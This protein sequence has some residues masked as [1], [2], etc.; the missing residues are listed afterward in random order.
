MKKIISIILT[1]VMLSAVVM[2]IP[3]GA[4]AE[5]ATGPV[6]RIG[7]T[8]YDT[9]DDAIDHAQV[10]DVIVLL[11]D[12]T[13]TSKTIDGK[14][15]TIKGEGTTK[16]IITASTTAK[17]Y[18]FWLKGGA[19]VKFENIAF[20]GFSGKNVIIYGT[21]DA[22][23]TNTYKLT[24]DNCEF[25][26]SASG[27][28][29]GY[30]CKQA[31]IKVTNSTFKSL[32]TDTKRSALMP[33][34]APAI[35]TYTKFENVTLYVCGQYIN[36]GAQGVI[37]DLAE[38]TPSNLK[39]YDE[40]EA[41]ELLYT[42]NFN[43]DAAFI[44]GSTG[45][46][47]KGHMDYTVVE[48]GAGVH[49]KAKATAQD[50]QAS[51]WG[52]LIKDLEVT[53]ETIYSMVYK[54]KAEGNNSKNN[55]V[56]VGGL[57][58]SEAAFAST[59]GIYNVYA[60]HNTTN[61]T[62]AADADQRTALSNGTGKVGSY[63]MVNTKDDIAVD[64]DGYVTAL[65]VYD[66]TTKTFAN[67][68]LKAGATDLTDED[69][70]IKFD[71]QSMTAA[72]NGTDA[73]Y[74]CFWTYTFYKCIDTTIKNVQFYKETLWETTPAVPAGTVASATVNGQTTYYTEFAQLVYEANG[75]GNKDNR[76]TN[77]EITLY[78]DVEMNTALVAVDSITVKAAEGL[79]DTP[80]LTAKITNN[81]HGTAYKGA[82]VFASASNK[83]AF[84]D[85]NIVVE[86]T[87][88]PVDSSKGG[89]SLVM[90][91]GTATDLANGKKHYVDFDNVNVTAVG[92]VI[93][94]YGTG[95]KTN[96]YVT[97][98]GGSIV[99]AGDFIE[100]AKSAKAADFAFNLTV[101]GGATFNVAKMYS[102]PTSGSYITYANAEAAKAAG[103][104]CY[105]DDTA[106]DKYFA[107]FEE[108]V[109]YTKANNDTAKVIV[110]FEDT[111]ITQM[112][113]W[114]EGYDLTIKGATPNVTL[115]L[116]E[117]VL[118]FRDISGSLGFENLN[119][120]FTIAQGI[121]TYTAN[122]VNLSFTNVNM[123][124]PSN[125]CIT[126]ESGCTKSTV[127]M[128]NCNIDYTVTNDT[129][130]LILAPNTEITLKVN[131]V[132]SEAS[133]HYGM[134]TNA[135]VTLVLTYPIDITVPTTFSFPICRGT[136][137]TDYTIVSTAYGND[138]TAKANGYKFRVGETEGGK[139]GE[140]YFATE[141]EALEKVP[142]GGKYKNLETGEIKVNQCAHTNVVDDDPVAATCT[143]TGLTAGTHCE[144]CGEIFDAQETTPA[145]GHKYTAGQTTC[146]NAG[147]GT[148][149]VAAI[150][151]VGYTSLADALAAVPENGADVT[152]ITLIA[153]AT[154]DSSKA[155]TNKKVTI[156]GATAN[157]GVTLTFKATGTANVKSNA[158]LNFDNLKI[159]L[160]SGSSNNVF[161]L[162]GK[163]INLSFNN[164][165]IEN[166]HTAGLNFIR[167]LVANTEVE[168]LQ[169]KNV[170]VT[171]Y[172]GKGIGLLATGGGV[173]PKVGSAE[174]PML[175]ENVTGVFYSSAV[176]VA[177]GANT[178][179][180]IYLKVKDSNVSWTNII[181]IAA[182]TATPTIHI[183]IEN[184]TIAPT[185][186]ITAI[187]FTGEIIWDDASAEAYGYRYRV[188]DTAE[189]KLN[190]VYF[191]TKQ[192]ATEY[193][194]ANGGVVHNICKQ[195]VPV[196]AGVV[197]TAP[198]CTSEGVV[199]HTCSLCGDTYTVTVD[200]VAHADAEN[201]GNHQCET[202][203]Y[204]FENA[205]ADAAT[206]GDH[207]CDECGATGITEH[208]DGTDAD[209]LCDNGCGQIA[210]EGHH[211]GTATCMSGAIC[212]ECNEAYGNVD[213]TNHTRANTTVEGAIVPSCQPGYTGDTYC[214]CGVKIED[215]QEIPAIGEHADNP[216]DGD[217]KCEGCTYVFENACA[218]VNTDDDHKC[219]DC[220]A[221]LGNC[222]DVNTDNDHNCDECGAV[223]GTC[224]DAAGD[225]NHACDECGAANVTTCADAAG[226]NNHACD[227][228]G[229]ANVTTCADAAGDGNHTC[230]ECDAADVT[231]HTGGTA[232]CMAKA[233]CAECNAE[234]GNVDSANHT[235][236]NTTV[237]NAFAATCVE[238]GYTGDTHCEC[239]AKIA[240]GTAISATG[241]HEDADNDYKCDECG[242]PYSEAPTTTA[243]TTTAPT[244]TAPTTTKAPETTE[245]PKTEV[246]KGCKGTVGVAG[247][248]LV[249]ALGSCAVYV[250][251][252]RK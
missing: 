1:I 204:V 208:T 103:Y 74:M 71:E 33:S 183:D 76:W 154:W 37:K 124:L 123:T 229:A 5:E 9:L 242:A 102:A 140:V 11:K 39:K 84:K 222:S 152:E 214:E 72:L 16:P 179:P 25:E 180:V 188:G 127:E 169:F 85:I 211:G 19:E 3:F 20:K 224:S 156:K 215:G 230:D 151:T 38:L 195:H 113:E 101:T 40:A 87:T 65:V 97:V 240:N 138:E 212:E 149:L 125:Y 203:T 217:H 178:N 122:E 7:T 147:C 177:A 246:P 194:A 182:A 10:G 197:D 200:P 79:A 121:I 185:T 96:C 95:E 245:A 225:G 4:F 247:F 13:A 90:M 237:K 62:G 108:A 68:Y 8:D 53:N 114:T 133:L 172:N 162:D 226:D 105:A 132:T 213:P 111:A 160:A 184:S 233:K 88:L 6:A 50:S 21:K 89:A 120:N 41:G 28:I 166:T 148:D 235:R 29:Y 173:S 54:A 15:I 131:N 42:V 35:A 18:A 56:G 161:L 134:G 126:F 44:P 250:E 34:N 128:T 136:E 49:I 142:A 199:T 174:K 64:T 165:D 117:K 26:F 112:I 93:N 31:E 69:S 32:D 252:K 231:Q 83:V 210:D 236:A 130:Y 196:D 145:L 22:A 239:G 104:T 144:D 143:Q 244:T 251:K 43:G 94:Q 51:L 2:T 159:T 27:A 58:V 116:G 219:D 207:N 234:Y 12:M 249:A 70:W 100:G 153:N 115:T 176:Y 175:I 60:N 171:A 48:N 228:C 243:P 92:A 109:A 189:G 91:N 146:A 78:D 155:F 187:P 135:K 99:A 98:N 167:A 202:C 181:N 59:S 227:E 241:E 36:T 52:G 119:L 118:Q 170:N 163:G 61:S 198:T 82:F 205:C 209:H 30:N 220:Q 206:D 45:A 73:N 201:D 216:N 150:G 158:T 106:G 232:T 186:A 110:L 218:D 17:S 157:K 141:A 221:V 168:S 139:P 248:A 238:A 57:A 14:K 192:A 80:T 67:Y 191:K 86:D 190:V 63:V 66:G 47:D 46:N 75:S 137:G 23:D 193:A 77:F 223:L 107:T 55:S 164:C 129:P 24:I 81:Y